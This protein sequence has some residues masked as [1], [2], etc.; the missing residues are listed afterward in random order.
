MNVLYFDTESTGLPRK[1]T[2][3]YET[4]QPNITQLGFILERNGV[5]VM[6]V[7]ALI[8][9][10]NWFVHED[11][12]GERPPSII[13]HKAM[14]VTGI[15]PELCEAE[16]IPIADAVELFVIAAE[17]ADVIVCH[18][19]AFDLKVLAAEYARLQPKA[20][21][22]NI[23]FAGNP[24]LCT[25]K[26]ATPICKIPKANAKTAYKWPR[27]DEA[28]LFFFGEELENAHSAI[29]D[30]KATRRVFHKLIELGAFDKDVYRLARAGLLRE[31]F[32]E[33]VCAAA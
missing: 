9:P 25:M 24:S 31:D 33:N 23:V 26:A 29:V 20:K 8:K 27:L 10:D 32:L 2:E 12:T 1:C 11:A 17:H 21:D 19:T 14:D 28:M 3:T 13:S 30:I 6:T 7:D 15:T 22:P 18:N 4:I 5:D 16:G